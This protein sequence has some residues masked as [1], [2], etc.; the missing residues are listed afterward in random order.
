MKTFLFILRVTGA[1]ALLAF[2]ICYIA[3]YV[4]VATASI[5]TSI[6]CFALVA[7]LHLPLYYHNY[8]MNRRRS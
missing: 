7:A 1:V 5:L 4:Q 2:M 8:F 3:G 6:A